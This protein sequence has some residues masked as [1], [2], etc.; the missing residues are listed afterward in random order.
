MEDLRSIGKSKYGGPGARGM[1]TL[2]D[3]GS[4]LGDEFQ[5]KDMKHLAQNAESLWKFLDDLAENNE[6][7]YKKFI[8]QQ[9]KAAEEAHQLE[10][11]LQQQQGKKGSESSSMQGLVNGKEPIM[12]VEAQQRGASTSRGVVQIWSSKKAA[13]VAPATINGT[14]LSATSTPSAAD[15][16]GLHIP[17][18]QCQSPLT[19]QPPGPG[20]QAVCCYFIAVNEDTAAL[21]MRNTPAMLRLLLA[22]AACQFVEA[23]NGVELD[24]LSWKVKVNALQIAAEECA[25]LEAERRTAAASRAAEG[26]TAEGLPQTLLHQLSK[27][28][29]SSNRTGAPMDYMAAGRQGF[30]APGKA[31]AAKKGPLIIEL[32]QTSSAATA[33]A[34]ADNNHHD[35][36]TS[37]PEANA[38]CAAAKVYSAPMAPVMGTGSAAE[39]SSETTSAGSIQVTL[40]NAS[41][42]YA[43]HVLLQAQL[44]MA[45]NAGDVEM[46]VQQGTGTTG[47]GRVVLNVHGTAEL[48][49]DLPVAVD[50]EHVKAK[51]DTKRKLLT[52]RLF[53]RET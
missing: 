32:Q 44:P 48:S 51:F 15:W 26:T 12:V 14:C 16:S 45:S 34:V 37:T 10:Q 17:L 31:Q 3:I 46:E 35:A 18:L 7:E 6:D 52:V 27:L 5:G 23:K 39:A 13:G 49:I 38:T 9:A 50:E 2:P 33:A 36:C 30:T 40:I 4:L 24:R 1:G 43:R 42:L 8:A 20:S 47:T 29:S 19:T 22:A 21:A 11:Q 41:E 28:S 53:C 25:K